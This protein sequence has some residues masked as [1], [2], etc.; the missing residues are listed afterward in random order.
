MKRE[1]YGK[2]IQVLQVAMRDESPPAASQLLLL[3]EHIDRLEGCV[4]ELE[5]HQQGLT[6]EPCI[7][8]IKH[9]NQQS[10]SKTGNSCWV[11]FSIVVWVLIGI[12]LIL[13]NIVPKDMATLTM[14]LASISTFFI[15]LFKSGNINIA[16]LILYVYCTAYLQY[17][18]RLRDANTKT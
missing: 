4:K 14:I 2:A 6:T 15:W 12:I 11:K 17:N 1:Y 9:D 18:Y 5:Q 3:T 13:I 16:L 10:E 7:K 8:G